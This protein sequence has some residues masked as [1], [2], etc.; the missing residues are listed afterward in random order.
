MTS[1]YYKFMYTNNYCICLNIL[2]Y[3]IFVTISY[4]VVRDLVT[5]MGRKGR[6]GESELYTST[7]TLLSPLMFK[8]LKVISSRLIQV[9]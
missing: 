5:C 4:Y 9:I 2:G 1:K 8:K 7:L 6:G 3:I